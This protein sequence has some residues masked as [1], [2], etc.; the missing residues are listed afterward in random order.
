MLHR[1]FWRPATVCLTI[2]CL[3][4]VS[5]TA[6]GAFADVETARQRG[7]YIRAAIDTGQ[8]VER[9]LCLAA[10]SDPKVQPYVVREPCTLILAAAP[11]TQE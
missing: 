2:V 8:N 6:L 10:M 4:I 1:S 11:Q 3:T 9:V 7:E 5:Q